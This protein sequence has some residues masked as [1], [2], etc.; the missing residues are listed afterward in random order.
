MAEEFTKQFAVSGRPKVQVRLDDGSVQVITSDSNQVEFR[1]KFE[2]YTLNR[3]LILDTRQEG[4]EVGLTARTKNG[5]SIG[6]PFKRLHA[7]IR[8]P[9]NADL[10]IRTGDGDIDVSEVNGE[11][12]LQSGDGKI[13]VT[14][15]NGNVDL[16]SGDGAINADA[17]KGTIKLRTGDGSI[18]ASNIDGKCEATTGDGGIRLSGRFDGLDL[19]SG[20]GGVTARA[21]SGSTLTN[22][23]SIHTGDG[24][25]DL[26]IP[27]D[28]KA[29]LDVS[30][31]DGHVTLGL[32]VTV[33]GQVSSSRVSGKINGGGPSV[34]IHSGDG[35]IRL[36]T[37]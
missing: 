16:H 28:L 35:S 20:D 36:G 34:L 6:V 12:Q 22:S 18:D 31:S 32:P 17:L 26:G 19:R 4:S 21:E 10:E 27:R 3:N 30:T 7:E 37:S 2:G 5:I 24:A 14:R 15:V 11:V 33:E 1:V 8:M 25:V 29:N 9:K 13:R 23:W